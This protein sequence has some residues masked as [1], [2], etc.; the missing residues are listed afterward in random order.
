MTEE[1]S[2]EGYLSEASNH[3]DHSD[4]HTSASNLYEQMALISQ[5]VDKCIEAMSASNLG[6]SSG[7]VASTM[8]IE[9]LSLGSDKYKELWKKLHEKMMH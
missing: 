4:L 3:F 6:E 5:H 2:S 9:L 7:K 1:N 8:E